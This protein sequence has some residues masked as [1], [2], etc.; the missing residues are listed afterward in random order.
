MNQQI[1]KNIN[2]SL[3]DGT[4]VACKCGGKNFMPLVRFFRFSALLTGSSKDSIMPLEVFVC[5]VCGETLQDLLPAELKNKL[6]EKT[7]I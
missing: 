5:G 4:P 1:N 3:K 2:V 7:I 6:E